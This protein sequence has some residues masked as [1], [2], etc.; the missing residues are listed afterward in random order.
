MQTANEMRAHPSPKARGDID[1]R[2][3]LL[4]DPKGAISEEL[5]ITIPESL[6]IIVHQ[7]GLNTI[8]LDVPTAWG[9][10]D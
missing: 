8:H 7:N 5:G 10:S 6:E 1:F 2:Q 3:K 4:D 9:S